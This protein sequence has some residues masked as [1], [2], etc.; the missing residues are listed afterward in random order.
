MEH[1]PV[2]LKNRPE[3]HRNGQGDSDVQDVRQNGLQVRVPVFCSP[4]AAT[5]AESGFA[6]MEYQ[7]LL[8][9]RS[10]NLG[11]KGNGPAINDL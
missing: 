11:A 8:S 4:L 2:L 10:V 1:M 3:L 7:F 9:L 6:G 5:C